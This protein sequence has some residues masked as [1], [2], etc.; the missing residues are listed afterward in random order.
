MFNRL[1]Y[2]SLT[3]LILSSCS[4]A[5]PDCRNAKPQHDLPTALTEIGI[6]FNETSNV[7]RC[8]NYSNADFNVELSHASKG[9]YEVF[10]EY[11]THFLD[12]GYKVATK[13]DTEELIKTAKPNSSDIK[14]YFIKDDLMISCAIRED[15]INHSLQDVTLRDYSKYKLLPKDELA[16]AKTTLSKRYSTLLNLLE[17]ENFADIKPFTKD[18]LNGKKVLFQF[19]RMF[20][21]GVE[22]L[23]DFDVSQLYKK[24]NDADIIALVRD[25]KI[26]VKENMMSN[27]NYEGI[28]KDGRKVTY[29]IGK[30]KY[31][32][33]YF[34]DKNS[35]EILG[36]RHISAGNSYQTSDP[37]KDL[38]DNYYNEIEKIEKELN[39]IDRS[40]L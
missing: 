27:T 19:T 2:I 34:F 30:H 29:F 3:L 28:D 39:A 9:S 14:E 12:N 38:I 8:T 17:S 16:K 32:N 40:M 7:C 21:Q 24:H 6:P 4:N 15:I 23:S 5:K 35:G 13:N 25:T 31:G 33:V 36:K 20:E 11:K 26:P 10:E 1:F 18:M 22:N 37:G